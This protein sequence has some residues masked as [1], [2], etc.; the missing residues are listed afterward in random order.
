MT[1]AAEVH[2]LLTIMS[3]RYCLDQD[4]F[5]GTTTSQ[6]FGLVGATTSTNTI[7]WNHHVTN[8]WAGWSHHLHQLNSTDQAFK[9]M[10]PTGVAVYEDLQLHQLSP[11]MNQS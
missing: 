2:S 5:C 9:Q 10:G 11:Q 6:A 3:V 7:S 4:R 8:I 1:S